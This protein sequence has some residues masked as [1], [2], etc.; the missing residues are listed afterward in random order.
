MSHFSPHWRPPK[1]TEYVRSGQPKYLD[2]ISEE[3]LS[4]AAKLYFRS[5]KNKWMKNK[6]LSLYFRTIFCPDH[7][8]L[9]VK[10]YQDLIENFP[11]ETVLKT[12]VRILSVAKEKKLREA[13][14]VEKN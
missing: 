13:I 5:E 9:I 3:S 6:F 14:K 1:S 8:L 10:F 11:P 7:D 4:Q 2:E 12:L